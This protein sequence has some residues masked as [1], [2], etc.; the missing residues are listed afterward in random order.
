MLAMGLAGCLGQLL[1]LKVGLCN[2][3]E[4]V[5]ARQQQQQGAAGGAGVQPGLGHG[6]WGEMKELLSCSHPKLSVEVEVAQQW[7]T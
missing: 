6:S 1:V 2:H 3:P 7:K 5:Q 4:V